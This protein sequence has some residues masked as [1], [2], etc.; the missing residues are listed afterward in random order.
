MTKQTAKDIAQ[1]VDILD[2][3]Q[4][5]LGEMVDSY[6][7]EIEALGALKAAAEGVLEELRGKA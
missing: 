4:H 1:V 2:T 7:R 5:E 6:P 3:R